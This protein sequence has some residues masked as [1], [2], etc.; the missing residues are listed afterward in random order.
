[1]FLFY[2]NIER[3]L[4]NTLKIEELKYNLEKDFV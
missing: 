2:D 4:L 3:N 1:M